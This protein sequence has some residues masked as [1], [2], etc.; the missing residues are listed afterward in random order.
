MYEQREKEDTYSHDV[1]WEAFN[2][3]VENVKD[4]KFEHGQ[5]KGD[6]LH[7]YGVRMRKDDDEDAW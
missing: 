2:G 4:W 1:I 6:Q 3:Y 7:G 5:K